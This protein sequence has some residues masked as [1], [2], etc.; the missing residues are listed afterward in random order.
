MIAQRYKYDCAIILSPNRSRQ[1]VT[2]RSNEIEFASGD[3]DILRGDYRSY[4]RNGDQSDRKKKRVSKSQGDISAYH[5]YKLATSTSQ[6][7]MCLIARANTPI[8]QVKEFAIASAATSST[9]E[10]ESTQFQ[11]MPMK[12]ASDSMSA[13]DSDTIE[14]TC[15]KYTSE[16]KN[17][18]SS[19]TSDSTLR[20]NTQS[21]MFN[22]PG[23][24]GTIN[25]YDE[26][27]V[28]PRP[29]RA[30]A[31]FSVAPTHGNLQFTVPYS[32][33]Y[34]QMHSQMIPDA[35]FSR[36]NVDNNAT[37][38]SYPPPSTLP[39]YSNQAAFWP[40]N[41]ANYLESSQGVP[42]TVS[43]SFNMYPRA[44]SRSLIHSNVD[45]TRDKPASSGEHILLKKL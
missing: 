19:M 32:G 37:Y 41:N 26:N 7:R 34:R 29:M 42:N 9:K 18:L 23:F 8:S 35:R 16:T 11:N 4:A 25:G 43:N 1:T 27:Y 33:D 28:Q 22:S 38:A 36:Q 39:P 17:G 20:P 30:A 6:S 13:G 31:T 5:N 40:Q 45:A 14:S 12:S 2:K 24:V 15:P 21:Q 44:P 3:I 10:D